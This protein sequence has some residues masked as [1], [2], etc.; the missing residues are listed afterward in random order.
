MADKDKVPAHE[1]PTTSPAKDKAGE[2][3]PSAGPHAE[4]RLTNPD[5]TPGS[6]ALPPIGADEDP[7]MQSTG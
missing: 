2:S 3:M 6:G 5:A 1:D 7:N 4:P